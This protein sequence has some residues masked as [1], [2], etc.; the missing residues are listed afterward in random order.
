MSHPQISTATSEDIHHL[1]QVWESSVR[2]THSFLNESDIQTLCPMAKSVISDFT[3]IYCLRRPNG[4]PYAFMGVREREIDML[5]VHADHRGAGAG[6]V[7]IEFALGTLHADRVDVNE[8]NPQAIGFYQHF[9]FQ[10]VGRSAQD[11][12][13]NDY[14]ILHMALIAS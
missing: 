2:A 8:E 13:G 3:P 7:L 4:E 12:Y 9:G 6:R 1:F 11:G 5:F 10:T 14:A